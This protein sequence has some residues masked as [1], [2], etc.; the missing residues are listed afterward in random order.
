MATLAR[1]CES[2]IKESA[3][4]SAREPLTTRMWRCQQQQ[5]QR[6]NGNSGL[7]VLV[8]MCGSRVIKITLRVEKVQR[9]EELTKTNYF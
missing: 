7:L 4:G 3:R 9:I 2:A 5:Q 8:F 6:A 1:E